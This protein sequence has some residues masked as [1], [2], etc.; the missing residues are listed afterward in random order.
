MSASATSVP[1]AE[2]LPSGVEG[3]RWLRA[4]APAAISLVAGIGL[5]YAAA[6]NLLEFLPT[7]TEVA[8]EFW[9]AVT[10]SEFYADVGVTLRRIVIAWLLALLAATFVGLV[11]GRNWVAE[12]ALNPL[13]LIGLA[14]P[15]PVTILFSILAFGLGESTT[16]IA[17]WLAVTPFVISFVYNGARNLDESLLEMGRS[18]GVRG[19]DA[20]RNVIL[21]Q[22]APALMS[23][24]RFGFA[25]SWKLI[26]L[27]EALS[28]TDGIGERLEFFFSFNNPQAVIAWTLSFTIV[29]VLVEVLVFRTI[30]R[31]LFA[32][33][34][35]ARAAT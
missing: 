4:A 7:P 19:W 1:A 14:L 20:V 17:L 6:G 31:R 10:S 33:R 25:M 12:T 34:G 13:I 3:R 18:Y 16:L 23:G 15:G 11:M 27:V 26:V 22:L 21:P 24:A 9:M 32:W 8:D 28:A 5:W 35:D 2:A 29:M 30:S